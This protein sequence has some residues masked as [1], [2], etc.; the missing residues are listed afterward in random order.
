[1]YNQDV[2]KGTVQFSVF[3]VQR[4][5]RYVVKTSKPLNDKIQLYYAFHA[6]AIRIWYTSAQQ[7]WVGGSEGNKYQLCELTL[8]SRVNL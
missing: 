5:Q 2:G 3:S 8:R 4:F 6:S 7:C 1:M